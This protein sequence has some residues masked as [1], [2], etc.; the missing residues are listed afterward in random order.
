MEGLKE[1]WNSLGWIRYLII[2]V[3]VV[4]LVGIVIFAIR[5]FKHKS[6]SFGDIK[7]GFD[8]SKIPEKNWSDSTSIND[9]V[10]K[11]KSLIKS[12]YSD[13]AEKET[14]VSSR[15]TFGNA[16]R[17]FRLAGNHSV[18]R[19]QNHLFGRA[20]AEQAVQQAQV[21]G[22]VQ[23]AVQGVAQQGKKEG[24]VSS[25]Q[26]F[27][28][29]ER[30]YRQAQEFSKF[31]NSTRQGFSLSAK[32]QGFG[33]SRAQDFAPVQTQSFQQSRTKKDFSNQTSLGGMSVKTGIN[34][35]Y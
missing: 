6:E 12:A 14:F 11:W 19:A 16:E 17:K 1:K 5:Y 24:F 30:R 27:G 4:I 20:E 10:S 26:N 23:G 22:A 34:Y 31:N 32:P 18:V 9:V 15:S 3:V 8:L 2:T 28:A 35:K 33:A 29:A 25:R 21:Q 7:E 13:D